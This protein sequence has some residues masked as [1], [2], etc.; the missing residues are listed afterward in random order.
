MYTKLY[1]YIYI[2]MYIFGGNNTSILL[3]YILKTKCGL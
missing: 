3:Q 1:I 2:Y